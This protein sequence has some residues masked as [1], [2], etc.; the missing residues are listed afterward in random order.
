MCAQPIAGGE[1]R[2]DLGVRRGLRRSAG[3]TLPHSLLVVVA[4][5]ISISL[6]EELISWLEHFAW[7]AH[8]WLQ[9]PLDGVSTIVVGGLVGG[10]EATPA[11]ALIAAQ[12]QRQEALA[13]ARPVDGQSAER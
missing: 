6:D 7:H 11:P 5:L 10:L 1:T 13:A 12:R 4:V 3:L 2:G 8:P 9:P